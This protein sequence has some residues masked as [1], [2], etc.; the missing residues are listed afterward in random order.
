ME[1]LK[2]AYLVCQELGISNT[3]FYE[4]IQSF[5]GAARRLQ[6]VHKAWTTNVW[7]DFAHAPSKVKATVK[8]VK[9]Q[10]PQ[11]VFGGLRRVAHV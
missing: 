11:S 4:A 9:N 3:Q 5:T 6:L 7:L 10:Y 8:A 1:N 2:A